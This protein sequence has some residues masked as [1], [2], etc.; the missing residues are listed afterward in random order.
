MTMTKTL[1]KTDV[2]SKVGMAI[3][4]LWGPRDYD[5]SDEVDQILLKLMENPRGAY[6]VESDQNSII[7]TNKKTLVSCKLYSGE[8]IQ[9]FVSSGD[10]REDNRK[11]GYTWQR[12]MPSRR[13]LY[14]FCKWIAP[15]YIRRETNK[16]EE[17]GIKFK[18]MLDKL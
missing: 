13:V 11:P 17:Y 10:V 1:A 3:G 18:E 7:L 9:Q 5:S 2:L 12:K 16:K 4:I 8:F 14:A 6:A 15:Y